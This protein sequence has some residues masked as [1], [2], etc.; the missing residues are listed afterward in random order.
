MRRKR[1]QTREWGY[2]KHLRNQGGVMGRPPS[3]IPLAERRKLARKN[4]L[5][6]KAARGLRTMRIT[7]SEGAFADLCARATAQ[8]IAPGAVVES[9]LRASGTASS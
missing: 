4:Y 2:Q 9:L 1:D 3:K 6:G 8:G 7:L 5:A